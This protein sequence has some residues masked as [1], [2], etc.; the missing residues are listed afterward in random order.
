MLTVKKEV[1][2]AQLCISSIN[3][4]GLEIMKI[5]HIVS[6]G[7]FLAALVSC[8]TNE[9]RYEVYNPEEGEF[10]FNIAKNTKTT[11]AEDAATTV[12]GTS[13]ELGSVDGMKF[14]LEETVTTLGAMA[15]EPQTKGTPGYTENFHELYG[16]F[17]AT[18][19]QLGSAPTQYGSEVRFALVP[20]HEEDLLYK[21]KYDNDLWVDDGLYF[22][23]NANYKAGSMAGVSNLVGH[24]VAEAEVTEGENPHPAYAA[25]DI[26]FSYTSTGRTTAESQHDLLFTSRKVE[27]DEYDAMISQNKGIPV[28]FHHVLSGVKF[29]IDPTDGIAITGVTFNGLYDSGDCIVSPRMENGEYKDDPDDH[30]S[31]YDPE[32]VSNWIAS[33]LEAS[34]TAYTA[35]FDGIVNFVKKGGDTTADG[36]YDSFGSNGNYPDSFAEGGQTN[37]LNDA[38]ASKTFWFI[39]QP[40]ARTTTGENAEAPV[41]LT[42]TYTVNDV[43]DSW[44]L[45]LSDI[46]STTVWKAGEIRTYTIRVD[47]VNVKI[48]DTVTPGGSVTTDDPKGIINSVKEN[49]KITNTGN[50]DVFIR[51]AI[52]GQWVIDQEDETVIMFGFTDEINQLYEV[53]SWYEDQFVNHTGAHGVFED[54]AGYKNDE[55]GI[56]NTGKTINNWVYN[57]TDRYFYYTKPVAPGMATG[58]TAEGGNYDPLFSSYKIKMIPHTTNQGTALSRDMY[59]TLEIATQAISARTSNGTLRTDWQQA[60]ADALAI[61]DTPVVKQ[62]N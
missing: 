21:W 5:R 58:Q 39:P 28:L 26:S 33:S 25:G 59:F 4:R 1:S 37:N 24:P 38:T 3:P 56:D 15:Y 35:S 23:L 12:K 51:A 8:Q 50:T 11:K 14:T 54:L 19:Y 22:F 31:G 57:S 18:V 43:E 60:W 53:E 16:G 55:E 61:D 40:M 44:T 41:T 13:I 45:N 7:L 32:T 42:I 47:E 49:V 9:L 62:T 34:G 29:A 6:A 30:S 17:N 46:I 20:G 27:S 52:V 10:V 36:T 2:E 48:E